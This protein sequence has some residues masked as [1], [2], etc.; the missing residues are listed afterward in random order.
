M[1]SLYTNTS[2]KCGRENYL[3][4]TDSI[5]QL[6]KTSQRRIQ[7]LCG[8]L[9]FVSHS[10]SHTQSVVFDRRG[11][12]MVQHHVVWDG[13]S[14]T[15]VFVR[16]GR[17]LWRGLFFH[18]H[19][20]GREARVRRPNAILLVGAV[21]MRVVVMVAMLMPITVLFWKIVRVWCRV[22][23]VQYDFFQMRRQQRWGQPRHVLLVVSLLIQGQVVLFHYM[24]IGEHSWDICRVLVLRL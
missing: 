10:A 3:Y 16:V 6:K 4:H 21:V 12:Q 1:I 23:S 22:R 20:R 15:V 19:L 14:A 5:K 9:A 7:Y 8:I 24:G 17:R 11:N 13:Q 2:K 18:R